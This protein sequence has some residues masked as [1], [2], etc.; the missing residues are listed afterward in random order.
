VALLEKERHRC[1][2]DGDLYSLTG[3]DGIVGVCKLL[4]GDIRNGIRFLDETILRR[5][6]EGYRDHAD[7]DRLLLAEFICKSSGV[8]K[9]YGS[10]PY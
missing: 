9:N 6:K 3:S 5:E 8:T 2:E 7:W 10:L 1:V 4:Q